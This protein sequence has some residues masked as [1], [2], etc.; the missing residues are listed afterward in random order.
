MFLD[1]CWV[2]IVY[3]KTAAKTKKKKKTKTSTA[4]KALWTKVWKLPK[5]FK[6]VLSCSLSP[7]R[8]TF[9]R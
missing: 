1:L 2:T 7:P 8:Y 5:I 3:L 9:K 6:I 4:F